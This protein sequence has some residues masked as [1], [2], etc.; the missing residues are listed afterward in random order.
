MLRVSES[1]GMGGVTDVVN[2]GIAR[3][4]LSRATVSL[5]GVPRNSGSYELSRPADPTTSPSE[6]PASF[7]RALGSPLIV[8]V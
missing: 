6:Y 4:L 1:P 8:P 2:P 3:P 5:P 7:W